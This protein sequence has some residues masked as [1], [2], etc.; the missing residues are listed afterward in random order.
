MLNRTTTFAEQEKG[1]AAR[2]NYGSPLSCFDLRKLRKPPIM[3]DWLDDLYESPGSDTESILHRKQE[4]IDYIVAEFDVHG[5]S[6][7][8][9]RW[10]I[11]NKMNIDGYVYSS[12]L[13]E[14]YYAMM[15]TGDYEGQLFKFEGVSD[16]MI[17]RKPWHERNKLMFGFLTSTVGYTAV[18][19][20][21][22][23][24]GLLFGKSCNL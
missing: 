14:V 3:T 19:I 24:I 16:V 6:K 11:E 4:A 20:V 23:I 15:E 22:F 10:I 2:E 12:D 17:W 5:K 13:L 8:R 21:T 7:V 18:V 1:L 9:L